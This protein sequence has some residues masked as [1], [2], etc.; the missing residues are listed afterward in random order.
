MQSPPLNHRAL[1]H[2]SLEAELA[3]E[4]VRRAEERQ[5]LLEADLAAHERALALTDEEL[6]LDA[7]ALGLDEA[8]PDTHSIREYLEHRRDAARLSLSH[9]VEETAENER[10]RS[11]DR[12]ADR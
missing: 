7:H 2:A 3:A 1:H 10:R 4:H 9:Q 12:S 8:R 5:A 6:A 11:Q